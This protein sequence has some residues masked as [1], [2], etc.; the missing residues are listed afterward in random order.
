MK[1]S[2]STSAACLLASLALTACATG[3]SSR[4]LAAARAAMEKSIPLEPPGDYFVGRRVYK[5][6]Y[7]MWGYVRRPRQSWSEARL[8]MFNE[9]KVLAPDRSLNAIGSDNGCEYRLKGRFSGDL[10]YEPASNSTYP[11][12]V[13]EGAE[14][15]AGIPGPIFKDRSAIN[16]RK[17]YYP[18]PY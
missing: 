4:E 1:T 6:D 8:V 9:D 3:P 17:R 2:F 15:V 16:P 14:L 10:V 18:D 13:L 12:F 5:V 7:K 11:E